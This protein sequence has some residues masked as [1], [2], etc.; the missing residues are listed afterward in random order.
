[1]PARSTQRL[2][3]LV[4]ALALLASWAATSSGQAPAPQETVRFAVIGD[5]GTGGPRQHDIGRQMA[6][7]RQRFPFGFVITVGDNIYGGQSRADLQK[8]FEQPYQILLKDEV[9][10]YASLGNH[11]SVPIQTNYKLFNM[12][13]A[14]YYTF[15]KGPVQFFALDSS[16][17]LPAQLAWLE[18][19][20]QKSTA[21]WKIVYQH[22]PLYSSGLRHGP[23]ESQQS[24]L[25]PL[26]TTY[27]V[28]VVFAGH[29]HFYERLVPRYD[30]HHFIVGSGG[31]L[32]RNGIRKGSK[33]TAAGFDTDNAFL[34]VAI[35]GDTL[36]F[37]AVSRTGAI[38][39]K[40]TIP[41]VPPRP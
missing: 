13:G 33:D 14:R 10:F 32:R 39:D 30:F 5:M 23:T 20:L 16:L 21:P 24:N 36:T 38:V 35:D 15:V 27:G 9:P 26:L 2:R 31:Q 40:G 25:E 28:Q 29:E 18:G 41:R 34:I 6:T 37:E 12:N 8:K 22:H 1:V 19:L 4:V 3:R 7:V 11:D 17:A